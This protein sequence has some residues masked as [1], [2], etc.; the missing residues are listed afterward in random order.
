MSAPTS[1]EASF[2]ASGDFG[3]E[4]FWG[5]RPRAVSVRWRATATDGR[6][7]VCVTAFTEAHRNHSWYDPAHFVANG[8]DSSEP[9]AWVPA[10]PEWFWAAVGAMDRSA[11]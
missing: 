3:T 4:D 7:V 10:A 2:A 11:A 6:V 5:E 9:P 8:L 1:V